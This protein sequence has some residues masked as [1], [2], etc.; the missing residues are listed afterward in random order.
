MVKNLVWSPISS[1]LIFFS[2]V[3]PLL[4]VKH[5]CK[6]SLYAISKKTKE[7]NVRKW[8]K[9]SLWA[10]FRHAGP[11]FG[12]HFFCCCKNL[13]SSAT[14][15]HGQLSSCTI[16]EKNNDPILR[17]ISDGQMDHSDF[18]GHCGT[19]IKCP[20]TRIF[21]KDLTLSSYVK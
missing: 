6:L 13:V 8:Q 20:I 5:C 4:N 1:P 16:S 21:H 17:K 10:W 2:W 19:N 12:L 3:L 15:Y 18:T 14:Q 11:K 7:L 9:T